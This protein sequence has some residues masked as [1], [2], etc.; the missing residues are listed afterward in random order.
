MNVGRRRALLSASKQPPGVGD[1]HE[2]SID[3]EHGLESLI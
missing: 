1:G 2:P 3:D